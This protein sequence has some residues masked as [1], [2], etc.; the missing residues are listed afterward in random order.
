MISEFD[1]KLLE[2]REKPEN[3]EEEDRLKTDQIKF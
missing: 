1:K 3:K 2:R